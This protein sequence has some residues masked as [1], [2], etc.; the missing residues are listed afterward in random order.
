M[1]V[2]I[3][4]ADPLIYS[5]TFP[6]AV[7]EDFYVEKKKPIWPWFAIGGGGIAVGLVTGLLLGR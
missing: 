5:W 4:T 2:T 3:G 7:I 6:E 1:D